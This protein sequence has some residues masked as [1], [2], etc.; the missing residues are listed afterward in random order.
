LLDRSPTRNEEGDAPLRTIRWQ[1]HPE[2]GC[3]WMPAGRTTSPS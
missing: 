1:N 3:L 2:C